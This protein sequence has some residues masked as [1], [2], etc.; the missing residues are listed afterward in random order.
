LEVNLGDDTVPIIF[1]I[2]KECKKSL[3]LLERL[4]EE[5]LTPRGIQVIRGKN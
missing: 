5:A 2:A 1:S 3:E 4:L